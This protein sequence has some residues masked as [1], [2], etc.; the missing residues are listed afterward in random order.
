MST[1]TGPLDA[2]LKAVTE[3]D[4]ILTSCMPCMPTPSG[5]VVL[6][7][8]PAGRVGWTAGCTPFRLMLSEPDV[9]WLVTGSTAL[10]VRSGRL[11]RIFPARLPP[12][13]GDSSG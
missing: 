6:G 1:A 3:P 5:C 7:R 2:D 9:T 12:P 10:A 8:I 4:E 13:G 11:H